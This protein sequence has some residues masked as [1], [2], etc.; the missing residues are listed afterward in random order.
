MFRTFEAFVANCPRWLDVEETGH[1]LDLART[2]EG[3]ADFD[4]YRASKPQAGTTFADHIAQ[5]PVRSI[6]LAL[7]RESKQV[8][9]WAICKSYVRLGLT[10]EV[11]PL[12]KF[13]TYNPATVKSWLLVNQQREHV[14][15]NLL[16]IINAKRADAGE[17]LREPL[18]PLTIEAFIEDQ[19]TQVLYFA[20]GGYTIC[21]DLAT[22]REEI[23]DGWEFVLNGTYKTMTQVDREAF[24][25]NLAAMAMK[26]SITDCP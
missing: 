24:V 7:W 23:A 8:I 20:K 13:T 4:E 10:A 5:C 22:F 17:Q 21:E 16:S 14:D 2:A 6:A 18:G 26:D 3:R 1:A 11:M 9:A 25:D 12:A 19:A 15:T